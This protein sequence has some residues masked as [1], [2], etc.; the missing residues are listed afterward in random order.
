MPAQAVLSDAEIAALLETL[1]D[2]YKSRETYAQVLHDFGDVRP[3]INIVEAEGRHVNA[4]LGV[5]ERYGVT[6]PANRWAGGKAPRFASFHEACVESVKGEIDNV[7][8][9]DRA[10][11]ST[12]RADILSV[13]DALRSASQDRHLPAFRRCVERGNR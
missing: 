13:Y 7:A 10:L 11:Q 4:L 2:E 5:F 9:Y 12:R 1:D 6:P 3:F 8:I